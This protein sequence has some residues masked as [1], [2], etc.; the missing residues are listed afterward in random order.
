MAK[1]AQSR[2]RPARAPRRAKDP[3]SSCAPPTPTDFRRYRA[4]R[5]GQTTDEIAADDRTT[6]AAVEASLRRVRVD[7]A[8]FS[9]E[10][11]GI[12]VRRSL[13]AHAQQMDQVFT[14]A[15][16]ATRLRTRS[17]IKPDPMTGELR[18]L[19][20][21]EEYADH[22]TRLKAVDTMRALLSVVQPRDP[23]VVVTSNSQTN[24]LNQGAL[25]GAGQQQGLTSP[26]AVIRQI[27][28]QRGL[29]LTD[30]TSG[31]S[32]EEVDGGATMTKDEAESE[33]VDAE[34]E[35]KEEEVV[36][37]DDELDGDEEEGDEEED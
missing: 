27:R 12:E 2:S 17:I 37:E 24:I 29:S 31:T 36:D 32:A 10:A 20:E 21:S 22:D 33:I 6:P 16:A 15:F 30:G 11:T 23:A 28:A 35:D 1:S 4:H 5:A 19:E 14:D 3:S 8:R 18:T 9:P 34:V 7:N 26:E 25:P 13:L